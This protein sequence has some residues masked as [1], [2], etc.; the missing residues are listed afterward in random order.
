MLGKKKISH[1]NIL[2]K[3]G[4]GGIG[5]V[6]LAEDSILKRKVALKFLSSGQITSDES[7]LR[8]RREA[9]AAA[10][11]NHPNIITIYEIGE[12][13]NLTF[14]AM[15]YI[16][17]KT[18]RVLINDG[19]LD[20]E[21]SVRYASQIC[22]GLEKANQAGIV[23]RDIKPE[24][25]IID[26]TD[27]V[28]ILDFGL[29][30]L[31]NV[32]Q[33]TKE[34]STLGTIKYMSPEQAKGEAVDHHT[35]IWSFGVVL[36]EMLSGRVP[37]GGDYEQAVI[38]SIL[39]EEP[40]RL[41]ELDPRLPAKLVALVNKCLEKQINRR[42]A[43]ITMVRQDLAAIRHGIS[44]D[45][46]NKVRFTNAR[47]LLKNR[48]ILIPLILL[49]AM[50]I[51]GGT[52][53]LLDQPVIIKTTDTKETMAMPWENSIAVLPFENISKDEN[54]AYFCDG[55]TE[56]II[57]GLST[58]NQ[59]K[60]ISRTSVM[61]F[62]GSGKTIPEIGSLLRVN[63]VLEGSVRRL[64][65]RIRVTAQLIDARN[66]FHVWSQDYDEKL[67]D[68]FELQDNLS[69]DIIKSMIRGISPDELAHANAKRLNSIEAYEYFMKGRY[70]HE[71]KYIAVDTGDQSFKLAEMMFKKAIDLDSTF[72][73]PYTAL[74]DLYHSAY[75][76][77]SK[78]KEE[79]QIQYRLMNAFLNRAFDL[80]STLAYNYLVKARIHIISN[81]VNES[82]VN[83]K[84]AV[85]INPNGA[86]MNNGM[87]LFLFQ[88]GLH[89]AAQYYTD[90]AVILDPLEPLFYVY[91]GL[92]HQWLGEMESA[93]SD[94]LKALQLEPS[95]INAIENYIHLLIEIG[96]FEEAERYMADLDES[97][98]GAYFL[99]AKLLAARGYKKEV[100]EISGSLQNFQVLGLLGMT[101]AAAELY[102][103]ALEQEKSQK[104]SYYWLY[105]TNP[106]YDK[107]RENPGFQAYLA[108]H[109]KIL[110]A[111][112][113]DFG[114]PL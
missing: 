23:H 62:K 68:I 69:H 108:E 66:D 44:D 89:Q 86:W 5:E 38:Y 16:E 87:A 13:E 11:L 58:I 84:T 27:R 110:E 114:G 37:F 60:V 29:A 94:Y 6:Y 46:L 105:K 79:R 88:R 92:N 85:R 30:K 78:S 106:C 54:H 36:F 19:T 4:A 52:Y 81:E 21:K 80:D 14:I 15:E 25:I 45:K 77:S 93:E 98:P 96:R 22:E 41:S 53:F 101:D 100:L 33:L 9:Q 109:K 8:F 97:Q 43:S 39:N 75:V 63:F 17:G 64:N 74:A 26:H 31:K 104:I 42:Y 82:F 7:R 65:D 72:A 56:Q 73:L 50:I 71:K 48:S 55:L 28:K 90:R 3:L 102:G 95:L 2:E 57:S 35:D 1:Y 112:L 12:F 49:T 83:F 24:N 40:P 34:S 111:N 91:R 20:I 10:A 47:F 76:L 99:Q 61:K 51:I 107:L 70:Y 67:T 32:S 18:L 113:K 103:R 59:L